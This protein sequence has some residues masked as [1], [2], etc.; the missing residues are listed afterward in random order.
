MCHDFLRRALG[1]DLATVYACT[2]ADVHHVVSQANGVFVVL[3]HD[4]G[5]TQ[6]AQ[7]VQGGEQAVV[8]A[9]M[10]TDGRLIKDIHHPDQPRTNLA[11]KADPLRFAAGQGVGTAIQGEVIQANVDQKL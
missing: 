7:V 6:I 8:V 4:H 10:K 11:G 3:D 1:N 2:R 9:L 5:V